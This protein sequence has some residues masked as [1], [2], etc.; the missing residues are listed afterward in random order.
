MGCKSSK[1]I[2]QPGKLGTKN[3]SPKKLQRVNHVPVR[4]VHKQFKELDEAQLQKHH[5]RD[6]MTFVINGNLQMVHGLVKY[7]RLGAKTMDLRAP[8]VP[9]T[10][11]GN[12]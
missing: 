10:L 1:D 9:F 12:I 6:V 5:E 3:D 8:A 7:H 11:P 2:S 4:T